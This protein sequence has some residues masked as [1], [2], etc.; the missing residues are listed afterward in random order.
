MKEISVLGLGYIGLPT[1]SIL[2]TYGFKVHGVDVSPQVVEIVNK[3]GIHIEEPGLKTLVQAAVNSGNLRAHTQ[4]QMADVYII[5]VPTPITEDKRAD[6]TYV[7]SA[8]RAILPLLK[9]GDLVILESTSPPGT[10]VDFLCP[11]LVETGLELGEDLFVAHCPE[12]VLP[13]KIIKELIQNIRIIGGINKISAQMAKEIYA[14]FVEGDIHLT[15]ATTAEMVKIME[16]TYRDVN[17]A[18][19]NEL[20]QIAPSLNIS[21][22]DVIRFANLH[23]RVNIHTP[24]PGVGGHCISVDP[25]FIVEKFPQTARIITQARN[26]NDGMPEFTYQLM[27]DTVKDIPNPKI[28]LLGVTYKPDVDDVR[29]SPALKIIELIE[30]NPKLKLSIYDPHVKRFD[31]ELSGFEDAIRDSDCILL[32]VDHAEFKYLNPKQVVKLMRTP[33]VIDTRN[34][35]NCQ[36]WAEVGFNCRLLGRDQKQA[37]HRKELLSV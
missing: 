5:A 3:G 16:N 13:G 33:N 25:W 32:T 18:L 21:A 2:A 37:E 31:Y 36:D 10:T 26:I 11:I 23:P 28:T 27:L 19:A 29:E 6:L 12:R 1:A 15:D 30:A 24:G 7:E 34:A 17:I 4:P 9:R 22:W 14:A 35:L 20:A 8:T